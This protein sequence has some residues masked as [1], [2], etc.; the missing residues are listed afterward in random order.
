[1]IT[2]GLVALVSLALGGLTS[3]AQLWLP[4][5]LRPFANSASGWTLLTALI[6]WTSNERPA[7]SAVL[8]AVS[9]VALVL[10][11]QIVSEL[12]GFPDTE[13]LFLVVGAVVGPF[14]GAAASWIRGRDVRAA[15]GS[16]ILSGIALGDAAFGLV[17][18]QATTGWFYWVLVGVLGVLLVA[19]VITKRLTTGLARALAVLTALGVAAAM[20][21]VYGG[22]S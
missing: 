6:V 17:R 14:V 21:S 7:R 22:L 11:Y 18:V 1:V 12:R 8:G 10:G 16:G 13:E 9:F 2:V 4:D 15:L 5:A 20:F 3:P 19:F